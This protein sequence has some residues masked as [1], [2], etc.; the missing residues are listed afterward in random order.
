MKKIF[1]TF[2]TTMLGLAL[3][4]P[5]FVFAQTPTNTNVG[6]RADVRAAVTASTT[7]AEV[8]ANAAMRLATSTQNAE[9]R[10]RNAKERAGAEINRRTEGLQKFLERISAMKRVSEGFKDDLRATID[11]QIQGIEALR[12]RIAGSIDTSTLR[13]DIQSITRSYRIFALVMPQA[14]IAAAADRIVTMTAT[15]SEIGAKLQ[16]RID[17]AAAAGADT[18]ALTEVLRSLAGHINSANAHAQVAVEG[19]ANLEPDNGDMA[20]AEANRAALQTAREELYLAHEEI[21]A[22]RE[23]IRTIID[24]LKNVQ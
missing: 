11:V 18:A 6:V 19:T 9:E 12:A 3:L 4:A 13:T 21:K 23:D 1:I 8:R 17:A 24:G 15:M 14:A 22:G 10:I 20:V 2:A 16:T 5:A 7:K